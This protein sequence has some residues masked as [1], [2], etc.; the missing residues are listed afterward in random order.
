MKILGIETSTFS[1]SVSLS[2]DDALLC[3]YVFNTGPRHNEV[4]IPTI[5][6]LFSDCGLGKDDLDAVCVSVGPG[7]FTSLRIGVST[8]KALCYSLGA[9]LVGVPSLEILTSNALWCGD[10][11]CAMTDAGRGEVFFSFYDPESAEMTPAEIAT[12]ESVCARV[13]TKTVFVGSG[14][15]LYENLIQDS[16]GERAVFLPANLNTPRASG[17]ALLGRKK[18]LSGHKDDPFTL[19]PFY[20]RRSA[21]EHKTVS[22]KRG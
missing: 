3:E 2:D 12:P 1:G 14:S 17:C 11:V 21:A 16:A 8:A 19:T 15:L 4:L 9:E 5:K 22:V 6:R 10:C 13:R 18:I 7:S 20:L